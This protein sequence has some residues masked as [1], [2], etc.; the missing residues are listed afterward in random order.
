MKFSISFLTAVASIVWCS[1][2]ATQPGDDTGALPSNVGMELRGVA[3][4]TSLACTGAEEHPDAC[5]F[6][7][8]GTYIFIGNPSDQ[9]GGAVA[10]GKPPHTLVPCPKKFKRVSLNDVCCSPSNGH[11]PVC[12]GAEIPV[13]EGP[14][15]PEN[16]PF[17]KGPF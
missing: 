15:S 3:S 14:V 16:G 7:A 5:L 10:P 13:Y 17:E 12:R 1:G 8:N 11:K 9:L 4:D 2:C 6:E